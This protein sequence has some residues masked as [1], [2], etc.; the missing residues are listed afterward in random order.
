MASVGE[1]NAA[2]DIIKP[3]LRQMVSDKVPFIFRG[4]VLSVLESQ[5]ATREL[6]VIIRQGLEAAEKQRN[7]EKP[8]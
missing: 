1:V 3:K 6:A 8:N 2:F 4:Q 5:E 7:A